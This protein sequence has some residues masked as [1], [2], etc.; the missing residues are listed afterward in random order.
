VRM[1]GIVASIE[2]WFDADVLAGDAEIYSD[3]A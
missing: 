2:K 1:A 3:D